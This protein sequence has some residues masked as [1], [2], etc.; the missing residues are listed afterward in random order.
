MKHQSA[1]AVIFELQ[2][3]I[4]IRFYRDILWIFINRPESVTIK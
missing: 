4:E 1:L 2:M 3:P